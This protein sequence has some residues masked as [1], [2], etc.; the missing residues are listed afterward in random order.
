[1]QI[2]QISDRVDQ[3]ARAWEQFKSVNDNRLL[4]IEKKG[5]VDPL[6]EEQLKKL[7]QTLCDYK[8]RLIPFP[9]INLVH[10][11]LSM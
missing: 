5:N 6:I 4:Q 8:T 9:E 3:L 10:D 2:S 7:D 1:M 11:L